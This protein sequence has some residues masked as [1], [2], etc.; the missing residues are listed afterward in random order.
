MEH[1]FETNRRHWDEAVPI[2]ERSF[3]YDVE[4]F[5][6]GKS[7]LHDLELTELGDVR[8]KTMLH[9]QCHFGLD[10]LSWARLGARVTGVDFSSQA[11]SAARRLSADAGVDARFIESDVYSLPD[12]LD[13]QFDIVFT[14]YGVLFWLPDVQRWAE[15]V[16]R[17]LR[18]GGVFYM[19]EFHPIAGIFDD[20]ASDLRVNLA[21]FAGNEPLRFDDGTYADREA[22]LT[23]RTTFSWQHPMG[24]VVTALIQAGL[25]IEFVH[26]FPYSV[27]RWF[28]PMEF[29]D[30]GYWHMPDD[31]PSIPLLYSIR[32]IKPGG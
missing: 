13:Q 3:F 10:T 17:F 29:R 20:S 30:D 14:S 11:I 1:Y 26:E 4:A 24:E 23:N 8:G 16:A 31:F 25:R 19:A 21:Y 32:A 2:H 12:R 28:P 22:N 6:A 15:V 27:E 5:K 9:L 7:S 18:P